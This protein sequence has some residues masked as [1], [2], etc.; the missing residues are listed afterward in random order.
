MVS[1]AQERFGLLHRNV[2]V[3][4]AGVTVPLTW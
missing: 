4:V 3:S 1:I 2:S